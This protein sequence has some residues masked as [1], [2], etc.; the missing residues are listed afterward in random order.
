[1]RVKNTKAMCLLLEALEIKSCDLALKDDWI[2][3]EITRNELAFAINSS[4]ESIQSIYGDS[5]EWQELNQLIW[6]QD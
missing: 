4:D 3:I 5:E 2:I 6:K 1:M